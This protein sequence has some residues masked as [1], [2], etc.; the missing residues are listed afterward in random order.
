[1]LII[2]KLSSVAEES[3]LV[4]FCLLYALDAFEW[5]MTWRNAFLLIGEVIF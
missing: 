2:K 5:M 1:M 4:E 3:F